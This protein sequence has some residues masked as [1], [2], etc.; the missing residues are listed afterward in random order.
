MKIFTSKQI[1]ELDTYT[2]TH[3]NISSTDLMERA[4]TVLTQA[5]MRRW[6]PANP[7]VVFAGPGNNGGD[8]L[9]VARMLAEKKYDVTAYLF[10]VKGTLSDDCQANKVRLRDS[11]H[12]KRFVEIRDEF[13]PPSLSHE[14]LVVDGLFGSGTNKPLS[15]GFA[16]LVKYINASECS[17]VS[18]DLP[19]GLMAEDNTYN[20][21]PNIVRADV[22]LT[23]QNKKLCMY[24]ADC[25]QYLG[26]V[27]I[28]DIQLS[29]AWMAQETSLLNVVERENITSLLMQ[30]SNFAHKGTMGHALIVAG[31]YGMAGAATLAT[32]ACLRSGAGKV[33]AHIPQRNYDIMQISVPEA[34]VHLDKDNHCFSETEDTTQYQAMA[35]GPG[36]GQRDTTAIALISQIRRATCPIVIDADAIN[37]LGSRS[38]WLQQL[39]PNTLLTPHAKEFDRLEGSS[40]GSEYERLARAREMAQR[41]QVYIL[42]KGHYSALCQPDGSVIFNST[43]NGGMATA[44]AGDVLTGII[45]GLLARGYSVAAAAILGSYLH[46]LAGDFA[47][48]EKGRESLIASDIIDFLPSAFKELYTNIKK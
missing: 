44:G 14:T 33:T 7:V 2:I 9:A 23:L 12:I 38:T 41:L 30:R 46:G 1:H 18:I 35:I 36:I 37:I 19:S 48:Q 4:A 43:G 34:V 16:S 6:S 29:K 8:A 17:V 39:P 13:D 26:E 28:L 21:T 42:L 47:A 15:G 24:F 31:C 11:K 45:T 40:S 5:I 10:N 3:E 20:I 25:Q 32:K 27:E 22:T